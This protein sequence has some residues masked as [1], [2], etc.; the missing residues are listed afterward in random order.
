VTLPQ[1]MGA[2]ATALFG[3]VPHQGSEAITHRNGTSCAPWVAAMRATASGA[4]AEVVSRRPCRQW[5]SSRDRA[6]RHL[7]VVPPEPVTDR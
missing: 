5:R 6:L 4:L 2:E 3:A 1:L 7:R